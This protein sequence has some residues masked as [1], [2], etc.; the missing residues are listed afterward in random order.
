M[1]WNGHAVCLAAAAMLC[2]GTAG[3]ALAAEYGPGA[4]ET[5]I[6][7]GNTMAYSG[8][9][10]PYG[11]IGKAVAACLQEQND[12]GGING[13]KITYI[14]LDDAYSPPK[15]VEQTRK[16]VESDEVLAV[17]QSLGTPTSASVRKYLN[18][19]GVPQLL[20]ASGGSMWGDYKDFPWTMGFQPSYRTEAQVYGKWVAKEYPDAKIAILSQNDDYGRDY[21]T[22]FLEG[23]GDKVKQIVGE[24]TYESTDPTVDSQ[25]INLKNSGA[26]VFFNITT[27]KFSAQAIRKMADIGWKPLHILNGVS[28]SVGA[29]LTPAGLDKSVGI[30][31]A[32]YLKDPT[33]PVWQSDPDYKEWVAFMDNA[34]KG[35][36]LDKFNVYA[37]ASCKTLIKI[38]EQ[39][40]DT[41]TREN[42]L[43]QAENLDYAPPMVLP[44]IK[45]KTGPDD[46]F[47]VEQMQLIRF[48]GKE[49]V[50]FG[51][52]LDVGGDS[53]GS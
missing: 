24:Q 31:S 13:R 26:D 32:D 28:N 7:I 51:E 4:S 52:I 19:K 17:V 18:Q 40:G 49:W 48:D 37:Y 53:G 23:L 35:D 6:K 50:R 30:I 38:I 1:T 15:T 11:T 14:T 41:L 5:E 20:I 46:H 12:K 33:D 39:M 8:P 47:P 29:V 10:S 25:I 22:G 3:T 2:T 42:M 21:R 36:K 34:Y 43:K 44:G 9:V 27:A 45:V 16:L